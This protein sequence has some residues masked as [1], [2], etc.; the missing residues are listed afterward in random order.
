MPSGETAAAPTLE[1]LETRQFSKFPRQQQQQQQTKAGAEFLMQHALPGIA[2]S[3]ND[4]CCWRG[5]CRRAVCYCFY[6]K[7]GC[8]CLLVVIELQTK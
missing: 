6:C 3:I 8:C 2:L 1:T 4:C 5:C 7:R